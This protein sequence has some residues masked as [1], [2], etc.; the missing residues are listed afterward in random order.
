M[1]AQTRLFLRRSKVSAR[2]PHT[3]RST[4]HL[5]VEGLEDRVVPAP[6]MPT[7][8]YLHF[9]IFLPG[10][11]NQGLVGAGSTPSG[12]APLQLRTAYGV[13]SSSL[14]GA[15]Q[16]IAIVD[17]YNDTGAFSD[18]DVFDRVDGVLL[19]PSFHRY[20]MVAELVRETVRA[21]RGSNSRHAR[22]GA[23]A[24]HA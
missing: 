13:N 2:K 11:G 5:K 3:R 23:S 20:E 17:M 6:V 10:S 4:I 18:L 8:D 21:R 14:T 7:T 9:C 1:S 19:V 16:T 15:G 22:Y 24:D 12:Y